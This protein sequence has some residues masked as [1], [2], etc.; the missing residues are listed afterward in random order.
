MARSTS[1]TKDAGIHVV[2]GGRENDWLFLDCTCGYYRTGFQDRADLMAKIRE[3]AR[4]HV[5]KAVA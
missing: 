2:H 3:H 1:F 5:V 4:L